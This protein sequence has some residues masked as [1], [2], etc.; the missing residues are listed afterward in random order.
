MLNAFHIKNGR[1][2]QS[3][4]DD[5]LQMP[6]DVLWVDL[7]DPT[8]VERTCVERVLHQRLP[9]EH[10]LDELEVT[11]RFYEDKHGLHI[12]TS[13]LQTQ[14]QDARLMTLGSTLNEGLLVTL[15]DDEL[16]A[17][18]LFRMRAKRRTGMVTDAASVLIGLIDTT[19]EQ[20]ADLLENIYQELEQ[21]SNEVLSEKTK[22]MEDTVLSVAN[23][24]NLTGKARLSLMDIQRALSFMLRKGRL[25]PEQQEQVRDLQRDV[26]SLFPHTA[27]LFDKVNFLIDAVR[28]RIN[29]EQNQIIKTFSIAAVVFLPPTLIASIYGMNFHFLPE[30]SW[31]F[32]YPLALLG[33][34]LSGI[35]PYWFFKYKGWL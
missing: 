29:I 1:L 16:P 30:L 18:R 15:H 31:H 21:D 22:D 19:I 35:A 34:V 32:G 9:H 33:M 23:Q 10:D 24:E 6:E 12:H 11:E 25:T 17:V 27:F 26:D 2:E 20:I 28:G 5:C 14:E 8:E 4:F 7:V 13:F 3:H